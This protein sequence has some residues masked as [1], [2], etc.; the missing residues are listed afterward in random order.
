MV[1]YRSAYLF[2]PP[3]DWELTEV[4]DHTVHLGPPQS[5]PSTMADTQEVLEQTA[6]QL[7]N[8]LAL[9][10]K[11]F[12]SPVRIPNSAESI[13]LFLGT[14]GAR[15]NKI[16][17]HFTSGGNSPVQWGQPHVV[18]GI[19]TSS[20]NQTAQVRGIMQFCWC[21][22]RCCILCSHLLGTTNTFCFA[23]SFL[24]VMCFP[25]TKQGEDVECS[26]R[27]KV[28]SWGCHKNRAKIRWEITVSHWVGDTVVRKLRFSRTIDM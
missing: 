27:S 16:I 6:V 1:L 3:S 24:L 5:A 4:K 10:V 25:A 12:Y 13:F 21:E 26:R 20:W 17:T 7:G 2:A 11:A 28:R 18:L 23:F 9:Q 15:L 8:P 14:G 22:V 19:H